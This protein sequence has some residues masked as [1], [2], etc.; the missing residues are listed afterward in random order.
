[1]RRLALG[2]ALISCTSCKSPSASSSP[3]APQTSPDAPFPPE[4]PIVGVQMNDVSVL[5]PLATSS[6][7]FAAYLSATSAGANGP[8]FP[9]AMFMADQDDGPISYDEL[10]VVA[11]RFD[12][13]FAHLGPITDPAAC[14]DQLRLVFQPLTFIGG[15][16]VADD[17]AVHVSYSITRAQLLAAVTEVV[18]ARAQYSTTDLGPVAVHPII[19]SQGLGGPLARSLLAIVAKYADGTKVERFTSFVA[20]TGT[21]GGSGLG[22]RSGSGSGVTVDTDVSWDFAGFNVTG[23]V[24]T[25]LE[26]PTLDT[27]TG[28]GLNVSASPLESLFSETTSSADNIEILASADQAT[29]AT[30]AVRQAAFDAALRVENPTKNSPNTIDCL[31]CHMAEPARVL[32]GQPMFGLTP[33]GDANAFV[34]DPSIPSADLTT[35]PSLIDADGGLN[36]HAFSYRGSSAMINQRVVNETA[37]NVFYLATLN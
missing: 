31:T 20:D 34:A 23:G 18:A 32:V 29:A 5:L 22:V 33:L 12:P 8:L 15:A 10:R 19:A 25:A 24:A 3:D 6:A 2:L 26:I 21:S 30:P 11:F 1:M 17:A 35:T 27:T 16:T 9:A 36:L 37:A 14:D 7:E 13:C 4:Q 28:I